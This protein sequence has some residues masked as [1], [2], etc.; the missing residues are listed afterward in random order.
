MQKEAV[1]SSCSW[2]AAVCQLENEALEK[3]RLGFPYR[4][5]FKLDF[6]AVPYASCLWAGSYPVKLPTAVNI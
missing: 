1:P 3:K 5:V 4:Y 6:N 2:T